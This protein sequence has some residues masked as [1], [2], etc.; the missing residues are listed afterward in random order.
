MNEFINLF[1]SNSPTEVSSTVKL[2]LLLTVFSVAPGILILMTC[3]TRIVI[4]L[5]FVRTSLATQNM[6]PNQILIGLALFLTFFIMAP[7]FSEINKEAL[8][9]LMDNKISLD[10][11]YTK[12]EKPIKEYMS[13]HTRQ[14][15]L[16]LFMNYAKMKKPES[17]QDIPLT[18]MVPAYAISELKTAFQMGFMI[19]I[20][21]LIIDMVVASV[22]MSMGMMMLPPVMIS[23]PFKILLFVLVDGWYLIVKSLLDSF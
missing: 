8:T 14:K 20:P 6:P 12:A 16:A 1:N 11:A 4:V 15:D 21:F 13:K 22:L 10:E 17:I 7:T 18:T 23:L 9:P 3:F 19:F 5:S 2:L